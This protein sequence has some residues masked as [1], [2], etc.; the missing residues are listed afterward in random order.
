MVKDEQ[1]IDKLA[2]KVEAIRSK[3]RV[4]RWPREIQQEA[5]LLAEKYGSSFIS[6]RVNLNQVSL[7]H[8]KNGIPRESIEQREESA[9]E[10][11]IQVTQINPSKKDLSSECDLKAELEC[12]EIKLKIYCPNL[13]KMV[14]EKMLP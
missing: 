1:R 8:W 10:S 11:M 2:A 13:A 3:G 6:Q 4:I 9:L 12:K 7:Y 14:F 5:V